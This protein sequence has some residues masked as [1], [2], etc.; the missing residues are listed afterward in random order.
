MEHSALSCNCSPLTSFWTQ[1]SQS[2]H[3][4][5]TYQPNTYFHIFSYPAQARCFITSTS[6]L[7]IF[8]PSVPKKHLSAHIQHEINP[9]NKEIMH[10]WK[11]GQ[12]YIHGYQHGLALNRQNFRIK[13]ISN[14]LWF[15][16]TLILLPSL[17]R[18]NPW[19]WQEAGGQLRLQATITSSETHSGPTLNA[20][21]RSGLSIQ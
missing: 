16:V 21:R 7:L 9:F 8:I 11:L 3:W 10:A 12:L 5:P 4:I 19:K 18:L 13:G 1:R 15:T 6:L 17:G 2:L 20:I 14:F